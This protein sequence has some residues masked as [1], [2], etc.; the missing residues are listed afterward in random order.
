MSAPATDAVSLLIDAADTI[1]ERGNQRD[2]PTGERSMART[3]AAFNELFG[4]Q[5]TEIQGWQFMAILKI[6]RSSAGGYRADDYT[7]QAG[8]SALAGEC[9]AREI[10]ATTQAEAERGVRVASSQQAINELQRLI[11]AK[12]RPGTEL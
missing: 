7:D 11:D 10:A 5:L 6:A 12:R 1:T 4:H 9:A 8:Y 3:V 2:K